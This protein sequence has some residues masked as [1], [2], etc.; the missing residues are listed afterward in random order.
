MVSGNP[1]SQLIDI[2]LRLVINSSERCIRT[3]LY[4]MLAVVVEARLFRIFSQGTK[5][6]F[7]FIKFIIKNAIQ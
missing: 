6:L 7:I 4:V 5:V 1:C 2:Y 3:H